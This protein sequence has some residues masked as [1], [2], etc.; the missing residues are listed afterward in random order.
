MGNPVEQ[1][2]VI[3]VP[4]QTKILPSKWGYFVSPDFKNLL[5]HALI[6]AGSVFV[7]TVL[8]A[9]SKHDFGAYQMPIAALIAFLSN[10]VKRYVS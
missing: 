2:P 3:T 1:T 6:L 7:T 9:L 5:I 10:I 4:A 8:E